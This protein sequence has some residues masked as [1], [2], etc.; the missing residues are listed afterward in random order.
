M[1]R[2]RTY[3]AETG[4]GTMNLGQVSPNS[5][6]AQAGA[7]ITEFG[8]GLEAVGLKLQH[9]RDQLELDKING[10]YE[11]QLAEAK[12]TIANHPDLS[13]HGEMLQEVNDKIQDRLIKDNP[14]MSEAVHTAFQNHAVKRYT[15]S[16]IDLAT[17]GRKIEV[18]RQTVDLRNRAHE[19]V[20]TQAMVPPGEAFGRDP[21]HVPG[22][23]RETV[24]HLIQSFADN[25]V[26]HP[27][28]A[29]KLREDLSHRYWE[30]RAT[31]FPTHVMQVVASG[32]LGADDFSMDQAKA[33]H[34]HNIAVNTLNMRQA[35]QAKIEKDQE[36]A[37][38]V[39][40][41][42]NA[43]VILADLI[44]GKSPSAPISGLLRTRDL[45]SADAQRLYDFQVKRTQTPNV[46][47]YSPVVASAMEATLSTHQ[48]DNAP[49]DTELWRTIT[50]DYNAGRI[51]EPEHTRLMGLY[52]SVAS[53]KLDAGKGSH[54]QDVTHANAN[55]KHE[56]RTSGPADKYDALSEQT[57]VSADQFFWR[58]M[59][60]DPNADPWA[61]AKEAASIFRPV[62]EKRL[63]ISEKDKAVL[64]DA[65]M[66]G[67]RDSG[68]ISPAAH[69][70]YREKSQQ[71]R[72]WEAVQKTLKELPPPPPPGFFERMRNLLKNPDAAAPDNTDFGFG[73]R[74]DGT[75]KGMGF[76]GEV[77]R[78]DGKGFS[79]ELSIG[80]TID[81]KHLE[82]PAMVPTLTQKELDSI[83]NDG[84][85]TDAI[86]E[87]AV[88]HARQRLADGKSPF[89]QPGEERTLKPRKEPGVMGQ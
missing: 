87:K 7:G 6:G 33:Q 85:L 29:Q 46:M 21:G 36:H 58:K 25:G 70:A 17:E 63:G 41:E 51:S 65:K 12:A 66:Q 86:V 19:L 64:D 59:Q 30:Q 79:T 48:F 73:Q 88:A 3:T 53:H 71:D 45:N 10:R 16:A 1:P 39:R 43:D 55:L 38:K 11:F 44:E 57:I 75:N 89:A 69:K 72:G 34:Y 9:T 76:M 14:E 52:R 13:R 26:L 84:P 15:A 61:V 60:Q 47:N 27:V 62:V 42:A 50:D 68:A 74:H 80:V 31:E 82:I 54:N 5:F 20:D 32:Q 77:R 28:A 40:Q 4:P 81:G 35:Q 67:L 49:L 78:K 18:E 22:Q 37:V 24:N 23:V 8:R 2:I 56:L 83:V